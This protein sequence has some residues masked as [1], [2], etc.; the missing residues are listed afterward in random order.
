M[1]ILIAACLLAFLLCAGFG[2]KIIAWLEKHGFIQ[3]L[4]KDVV[5]K[6]YSEEDDTETKED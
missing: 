2:K 4:H 1:K 5:E 3:P 6:I